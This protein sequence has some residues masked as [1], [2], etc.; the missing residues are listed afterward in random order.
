MAWSSLLQSRSYPRFDEKGPGFLVVNRG[1]PGFGCLFLREF[2]FVNVNHLFS[3][4]SSRSCRKV[5]FYQ[6]QDFLA[7]YERLLCIAPN[8]SRTQSFIGFIRF[9]L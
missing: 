3:L 7:K 1:S 2:E 8:H 5:L 4:V 9:I 6:N